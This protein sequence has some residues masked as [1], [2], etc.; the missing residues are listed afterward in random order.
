MYDHGRSASQENLIQAMAR[1]ASIHS[2]GLLVIDEIQ[3]LNQA[4]SGGAERMLNFFVQLINSIGIPVVL[5]G[6]L[7][8][9]FLFGTEFR[10]ARRATG[11]TPIMW[12]PMDATHDWMTFLEVIWDYQYTQHK[13]PFSTQVAK[14][15]YDL[16]QGITDIAI[17]LFIGTQ[18][19]AI[20]QGTEKIT[21]DLLK[22]TASTLFPLLEPF[23]SALRT[24]DVERL[25]RM[26]DIEPLRIGAIPQI[27]FA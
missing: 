16:C 7:K 14:Y 13:V 2:L 4:K 25:S 8:A 27:L 23:L 1:V 11:Y 18:C 26:E 5:V 20:I 17:K 15:M 22:H 24:N 10:Q 9:R 3:A 21:P 12:K 19:N 6:T